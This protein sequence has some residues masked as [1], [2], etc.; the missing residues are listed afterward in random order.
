ML[1]RSVIQACR[2][3]LG[4]EISTIAPI[5]GGDIN[6]AYSL[7]TK[8]GHYFVKYNRARNASDLFESEVKGLRLLSESGGANTPEVL[9]LS[10]Q[11]LLL[12]FIEPGQ[13]EVK[14]WKNLAVQLAQIHRTTQEHFGL[15]HKNF[16]GSLPQNNQYHS[17]WS[18]FY[19][20]ERLIPQIELAQKAGLSTTKMEAG[21]E[22]LFK[23]L[24]NLFPKEPPA[25]THGD[26]WSGNF[27]L[28]EDQTAYFIDPSVSFVHREMDIAMSF[29]FGGFDQVFYETYQEIFPMET[30][31]KERIPYYQL[32]YLMVHVN[33]FGGPYVQQVERI[34]ED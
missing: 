15:D 6:E 32:Y 28:S 34:L 18:D 14:G 1:P 24:P 9:E 17:T 33:L 2:Q 7:T 8:N 23:R 30:G 12:N 20:E 16:I 10:S 3:T 11:H 13:K 25:L 26:F 4:E 29:T 27:I 31:W 21:F 22:Q 5:T 19:R